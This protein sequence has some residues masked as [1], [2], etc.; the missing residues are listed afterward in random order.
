MLHQVLQQQELLGGELDLF[1]A[2]VDQV[3]VDIHRQCAVLH[4]VVGRRGAVRAA[5][6]RSHARDDFIG[7]ER[8]GDV[9][10]RAKFEPDDAIGFFRLRG[11][12]DD[13]DGGGRRVG[14]N[15]ATEL[16]A[17]ESWQHQVEDHEVGRITLDL[18]HHIAAGLHD[19]GQ[20]ARFLQVMVEEAADIRI[21]LGDKDPGG[22][23]DG[24]WIPSNTSS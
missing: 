6:Q 20:E 8:L 14:A 9:I 22:G 10:V 19:R 11:Q 16:Q 13:R 21:I 23:A 2:D 12:H 4:A 3:L 24:H 5:Q 17:I 18:R 15:R 1:G 7:A